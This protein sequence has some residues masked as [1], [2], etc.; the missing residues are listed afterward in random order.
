MNRIFKRIKADY[1]LMILIIEIILLFI[2]SIC[3]LANNMFNLFV[4]IITSGI[5]ITALLMVIRYFINHFISK[6]NLKLF[7]IAT[8]S[9][10]LIGL[11]IYLVFVFGRNMEYV[12]DHNVY[13]MQQNELHNLFLDSH[14]KG[15]YA[16]VKSCWYSDYSYF[17]NIFLELPYALF[18]KSNESFIMIYY[19]VFIIPTFSLGNVA[20]FNF[21]EKFNVSNKI[22]FVFLCDCTLMFF[23][24]LH[25]A[26]L[27]GMP[28]IFGLFFVFSIMIL[29]LN[30]DFIVFDIKTSLL[31]S[32]L[33][34][35]L[36][37]TRRWYI[38]WLIGFIPSFF[39]IALAAYFVQ[40]TP[41]I[42]RI[43][44]NMVK[45]CFVVMLFVVFLLAPFIY[46]TLI[47]RNYSE[48]YSAYY[49]GGF[50]YEIFNQ[51]GYLGV[52]MIILVVAGLI[53]GLY[54]KELRIIALV[55]VSSFL[56]SIWSFT[57]IQNMGKHQSLCLIPY[58]L[59]CLILLYLLVDRIKV[60]PIRF[61]SVAIVLIVL[62]L[63]VFSTVFVWVDNLDSIFL[64]TKYA[65]SSRFKWKL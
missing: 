57:L 62:L 1:F 25:F 11:I 44:V 36:A 55:T 23:P 54:K 29:L 51:C 14:L 18:P 31:L 5:L 3:S 50:S 22:T 27:L 6:Y 24:L 20:I 59:T 9:L 15:F 48:E 12:S 32:G 30:K 2:L 47:D 17:I 8:I 4:G 34:I 45:T 61:I 56:L 42:K 60:K 7:I 33:I 13:F 10:S 21:M 64:T 43:I 39:V 41:N 16:I 26:S 35:G 28:D 53:Y 40:K 63:N 46:H 58:Y 19:F 49:L 65:I 38:F 52:L 37:V